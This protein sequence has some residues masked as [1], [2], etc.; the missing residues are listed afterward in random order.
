MVSVKR[1]YWSSSLYKN[2]DSD[3]HSFHLPFN[4]NGRWTF[5]RDHGLNVRAVNNDSSSGSDDEE[6]SNTNMDDSNIGVSITNELTYTSVKVKITKK[7][8]CRAASMRI[9]FD[10]NKEKTLVWGTTKDYVSYTWYGLD[11]KSKHTIKIDYLDSSDKIIGSKSYEITTISVPD[12]SYFLL[13][14]SGSY[15]EFYF[16]LNVCES[17]CQHFSDAYYTSDQYYAKM[18]RFTDNNYLYK[19][20]LTFNMNYPYYHNPG[21]TWQT[22]TYTIYEYDA[23]SGSDFYYNLEL[24]IK[25]NGTFLR[26]EE[27]SGT[28]RINVTSS[29]KY[30]YDIKGKFG[31]RQFVGHFVEK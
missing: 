15:K 20:L 19:N 9:T 24:G 10:K 22:G 1:Y 26:G 3:A 6:E 25:Q 16:P 11:P 17:E 23:P 21:S 12:L 14:S 27:R 29:G 13:Y 4:P 2:D 18:L 28:L 30:Y 31:N 7:N 5:S 8:Q